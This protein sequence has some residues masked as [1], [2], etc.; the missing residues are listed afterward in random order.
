MFND[1]VAANLRYARPDATDDKLWAVLGI[2]GLADLVAS[3]PDGLE[4]VAG[5]SGYRFSGGE[6]QRLALARLLLQ[7]AGV[8]I[9]DEATAHLDTASEAAVQAAVNNALGGRTALIIAH[10]LSTIVKAD[11]ILVLDDGVIV[12]Q[13]DHATLLARNGRYAELYRGQVRGGDRP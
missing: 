8:V 4:T 2:A 10:R 6:R 7:P 5:E 12:E 9:L 1:T 13:G 11:I 3:L